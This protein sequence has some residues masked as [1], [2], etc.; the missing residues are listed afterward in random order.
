MSRDDTAFNAEYTYGLLRACYEGWTTYLYDE[1]PLSGYPR[2]Q[3]GDFWGCIG[4]WY[5]GN[6][7]DQSAINYINS[8][9]TEL[10]NKVWLQPGF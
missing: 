7:Y 8:V 9:K 4:T 6:W 5:S 2:Y 10:A 3:A 1:T